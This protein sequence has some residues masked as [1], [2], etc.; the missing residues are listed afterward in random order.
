M[1]D[2][3]QVKILKQGVEFWNKWREEFVRGIRGENLFRASLGGADLRGLDLRSANLACAILGGANLTGANLEG[4]RLGVADLSGAIFKG[5]NLRGADFRGAEILSATFSS[6]DL[7]DA[8]FT[9]ARIDDAIFADLD[10]S[11]VKGLEL[12]RHQGPSEISIGTLYRSGGDIPE[13]FLSGCGLS[14][15]EIENVKLYKSNLTTGQA[16]DIL[17]SV[18]ELRTNP[19]IQFNSCFISY[20]TTD[21]KFSER[22]FADL[23]DRGVRC[24]YAPEHMRIGDKIRNRIDEAI[25]F[26][27]KLLLVL[28]KPQSKASG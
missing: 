6:S 24:W 14:D 20:S 8:D 2:N 12:V 16:T 21:Q 11:V 3:K 10:L 25:R 19:A 23:Q 22:L 1:A 26:Q 17:Y 9:E 7:Q 13:V 18:V 5:A 15:W 4:A 28:S 27:D